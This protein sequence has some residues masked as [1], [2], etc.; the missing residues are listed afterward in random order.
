MTS[1][2]NSQLR[3]FPNA[4]TILYCPPMLCFEALVLTVYTVPNLYLLYDL[5]I[6]LFL[7]CQTWK[8]QFI[9]QNCPNWVVPNTS[10]IC[11]QDSGKKLYW[12]RWF[13]TVRATECQ[14]LMQ[15]AALY[16]TCTL[17]G[18]EISSVSSYWA[19]HLYWNHP[20]RRRHSVWEWFEM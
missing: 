17:L 7:Y 5:F 19:E 15:H 2:S 10:L 6:L 3:P 12:Q 9:K 8:I 1:T 4:K 18:K 14:L 13:G 11:I 20:R 16:C